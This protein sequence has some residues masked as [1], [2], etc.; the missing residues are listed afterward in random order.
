MQNKMEVETLYPDYSHSLLQ[1]VTSLFQNILRLE[2]IV[3]LKSC[4]LVIMC[5]E[6]V[7]FS[8]EKFVDPIMHSERYAKTSIHFFCQN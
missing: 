3:V 1:N 4:T 2:D 5:G 8:F 6:I 7:H